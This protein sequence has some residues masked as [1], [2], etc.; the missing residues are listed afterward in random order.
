MGGGGGGGNG[1]TSP[2]STRAVEIGRGS[3]AQARSSA[4]WVERERATCGNDRPGALRWTRAKHGARSTTYRP[5]CP[6]GQEPTGSR[7]FAGPPRTFCPLR[8]SCCQRYSLAPPTA[9]CWLACSGR[10]RRRVGGE[11]AARI[12]THYGI[13]GCIFRN[14]G[15]RA[16][17]P[18]R[19][20]RRAGGE[21][22]RRRR[23]FVR[24][25]QPGSPV[26][27]GAAGPWLALPGPLRAA[28]ALVWACARVAAASAGQQGSSSKAA[29]AGQRQSGRPGQKRI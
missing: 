10:R 25:D 20:P 13:Q 29:A 17:C 3:G 14:G 7:T 5:W 19:R 8:F 12:S 18:P 22:G 1:D 9:S 6:A 2:R 16:S 24:R 27:R 4:G 26:K 11:R 28:I 23:L 15:T 21:G